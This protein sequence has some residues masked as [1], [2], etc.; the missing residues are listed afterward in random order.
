MERK[1][2]VLRLEVFV[3]KMVEFYRGFFD[4]LINLPLVLLLEINDN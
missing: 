4:C 3:L 2:E 1:G